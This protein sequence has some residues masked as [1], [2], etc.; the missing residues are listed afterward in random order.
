MINGEAATALAELARNPHIAEEISSEAVGADAE[1]T[2]A[3]G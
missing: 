1:Y 2:D 3:V